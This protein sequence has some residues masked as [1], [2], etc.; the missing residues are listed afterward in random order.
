MVACLLAS[1]I[2][3]VAQGDDIAFLRRTEGFWQAWVIDSSGKKARQVTRSA[4]DKTRLSWLPAGE[5]LVFSCVPGKVW[6]VHVK[7][8]AETAIDLSV[9]DT[10][11]AVVSPD[12]E[13][14]AFS[15][16]RAEA[17]DGNDI[18]ISRLDG[19][20]RRKLVALPGLQHEPAWSADGRTLYFTSGEG[21]PFH[22]IWYVSTQAG[23]QQPHQLTQRNAYHFD[24]A[25]AKDGTLAFSSNR[26][27]D[28]EIWLR[29]PTGEERQLTSRPEVDARPSFSGD[30]KQLV[31]E[32]AVDGV[33]NLVVLDVASG[34]SRALTRYR[35][36]AR[37]PVWRQR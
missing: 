24:V 17:I 10:L 23:E 9:P 34:K 33:P 13:R 11:D 5:E 1:S 3:S 4:C 2:A 18:W 6:R 36:G 16:I 31:I 8:G 35:E 14:I 37:S 22:D 25:V 12:G 15:F 19:G 7:R 27:G 32:A 30:G 20:E 21:G 29:S 26:T 28:Y